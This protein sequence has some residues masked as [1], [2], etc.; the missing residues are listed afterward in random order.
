MKPTIAEALAGPDQITLTL[1]DFNPDQPQYS[2]EEILNV[3]E[4]V[5]ELEA[6][7]RWSMVLH[8]QYPWEQGKVR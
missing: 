6:L 2:Y 7:H 8:N 3:S 5:P 1:D 4:S